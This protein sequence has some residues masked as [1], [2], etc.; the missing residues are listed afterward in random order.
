MRPH[1]KVAAQKLYGR[2]SQSIEAGQQVSIA[3]TNRY[4]T[5]E[6]SGAKTGEGGIYNQGGSPWGAH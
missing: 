6:Y 2:I 5:Y 1:S 4:N 3:V